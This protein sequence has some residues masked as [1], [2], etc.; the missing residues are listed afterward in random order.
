MSLHKPRP[1]PAPPTARPLPAAVFVSRLLPSAPL[2]L[3]A[4]PPPPSKI[5]L[6][7]P[8]LVS[9]AFSCS[10]SSGSATLL[11]LLSH[12]HP[13]PAAPACAERAGG[14][15]RRPCVREGNAAVPARRASAAAVP[16]GDA[17]PRVVT[18][19]AASCYTSSSA[20]APGSLPGAPFT[21]IY[22]AVLLGIISVK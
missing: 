19:V 1:R 3:S 17:E 4:G 14:R 10:F 8:D 6:P 11:P 5:L 15:A 9:A 12:R 13:L 22:Q 20:P 21:P 2:R 7:P 16:P 18:E